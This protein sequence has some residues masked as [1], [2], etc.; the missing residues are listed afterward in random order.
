MKKSKRYAESVKLIDKT[1]E[2]EAKEAIEIIEK[3][4]YSSTSKWY[5]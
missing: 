5:R 1:K 3:M 2:Y 4:R